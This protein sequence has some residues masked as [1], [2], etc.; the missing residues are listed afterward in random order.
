MLT[1]KDSLAEK[2]AGFDAGT[3]DYV[4]KPFEMEGLIVQIIALSKRRSGQVTTLKTQNL[5]LDVKA[6]SAQCNNQA[7]KLTPI[8]FKLL[9]TLMQSFEKPVARAVIM[10]SIWGDEQPDSNSLKVHVHHLRKQFEKHNVTMAI[11]N[12]PGFGFILIAI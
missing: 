4:L 8:T 3:D 12:E 5:T 2:V 9:K 1:A 11:N 7:L 6:R 10:Q